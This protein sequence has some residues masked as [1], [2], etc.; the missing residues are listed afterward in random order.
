MYLIDYR[1]K[2]KRKRAKCNAELQYYYYFLT[3]RRRLIT[4]QL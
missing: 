1:E 2:N 3:R 4:N